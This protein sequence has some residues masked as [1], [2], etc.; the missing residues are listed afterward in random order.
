MLNYSASHPDDVIH[1]VHSDMILNIHSDAIFLLEPKACSRAGGHYFLSSISV[2]TNKPTIQPPHLNGTLLII[3]RI[4]RNVMG[5]AS[6]S[7]I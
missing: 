3:Y 1:Y 4:M 7:K 2:Y 6:E 5:H